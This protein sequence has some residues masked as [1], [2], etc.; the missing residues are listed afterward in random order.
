[1]EDNMRKLMVI[2]GLVVWLYFYHAFASLALNGKGPLD[3]S[4]GLTLFGLMTINAVVELMR[5]KP[6]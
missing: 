4:I 3:R 5:R 2:L 1:M 6:Q